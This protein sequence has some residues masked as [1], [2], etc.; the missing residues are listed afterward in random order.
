MAIDCRV[1]RSIHSTRLA[2]IDAAMRAVVAGLSS[3][4]DYVLAYSLHCLDD[5]FLLRR[6]QHVH[7]LIDFFEVGTFDL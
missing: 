4:V 7:H 5:S 3:V 1:T 6:A 2:A